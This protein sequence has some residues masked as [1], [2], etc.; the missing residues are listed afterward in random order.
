MFH[1]GAVQSIGEG[2]VA[3]ALV[4]PAKAS[5]RVNVNNENAHILEFMPMSM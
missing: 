3:E 1:T 5:T 4:V 2:D